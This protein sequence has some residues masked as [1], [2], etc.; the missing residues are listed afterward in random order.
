MSYSLSTSGGSPVGGASP[1]QMAAAAPAPGAAANPAAAAEAARKISQAKRQIVNEDLMRYYAAV[2]CFIIAVFAILHWTRFLVTRVRRS[3]SGVT[4]PFAVVS[5]FFR[6]ILVRKVIGFISAGHGLLTL[7]YVA[8]NLVLIFVNIDSS[9]MGNFAARTGWV[10]SANFCFVIFLSLK[11]T[12]LAFLT[13]YSYERLNNLHQI[14]GCTSFLLMVVHAILYTV[15]FLQRNL[16]RKLEETE[17]IAGIIAAFA[18]LGVFA[19]AMVL[20]RYA[21]EA[22]YV[23]HICS[24][25]AAVVATGFHRPDLHE[26]TLIVTSLTGAIF[27]ADRLIRL[28]RIAINSVNNEIAV[29]PLPNGGTRLIITKAPALAIPGKHCFVWIPKIRKFETHPFTIISTNPLEFCVNSYDGFTRELHA[30]AQANPG[31]TMRAAVEGPYG[32]FPN[33]MN[34]DKVV[35]IAGGSGASYTFGLAVNLLEKMSAETKKSIV[36][37]WTAKTHENLSWYKDHLTTL[38]SHPNSPKVKVWLHVTRAPSSSSSGER[39]AHQDPPTPILSSAPDAEK[40]LQTLAAT[41]AITARL[42]RDIEKEMLEKETTHHSDGESSRGGLR[43]AISSGRP[44]TAAL[45]RE[46]I[47]STPSDQRVLVAA[48]GPASLMQTV[49]NTTAQCIK[50]NGPGVELHCEQFGW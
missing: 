40:S 16:K 43:H 28:M 11:N 15:Y 18:F 24:F 23:M 14:A 7:V 32:T 30:Y 41:S 39:A 25:I 42:E 49:R 3:P 34:Y 9:S 22:F 6:N 19:S 36:F 29:Y 10:L 27:I 5:R 1:I 33:P 17:Q 48:C 37:I 12:P 31:A 13:A 26:N 4:R 38:A 45:I 20:R 2:L 47:A 35:L 50:A 8:V 21:Y 46:A 44:D